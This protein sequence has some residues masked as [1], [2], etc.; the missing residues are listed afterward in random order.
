MHKRSKQ[1]AATVNP[2]NKRKKSLTCVCIV[3]V[4]RYKCTV[5]YDT[6]LTPNIS[7]VVTPSVSDGSLLEI[8]G[9]ELRY[10]V[11]PTF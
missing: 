6:S 9:R 2:C 3:D 1:A 11:K 7:S 5:V 4:I 8:K 10:G